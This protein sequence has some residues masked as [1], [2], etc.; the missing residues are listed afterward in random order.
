M[1]ENNTTLTF[2]DPNDDLIVY[3]HHG[4]AIA[5]TQDAQLTEI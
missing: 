4:S 3:L 2:P 5:A 1:F